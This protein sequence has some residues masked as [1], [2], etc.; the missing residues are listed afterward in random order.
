MKKIYKTIAILIAVFAFTSVVNAQTWSAPV[1]KSEVPVSGTAYYVFN[2]GSNGFLNRGA[3]WGTQA[4]VTP[5]PRQNA[6]TNINKWTTVNTTGSSWTF[7]YNN[8]GSVVANNY[9]FDTGAGTDLYTDNT[10]NNAFTVTETDATNHIFTIQSP[11]SASNY[12]GSALAA[13]TTNKGIANVV[14]PN[15]SSVDDYVKWKFVS[16]AN[17]DLYQAKVILDRYMTYAKEKGG[18]SLTT[19]ISTYN[20]DVTTDITTASTNLLTA[21]SRTDLTASITNPS[22]EST[23]TG[24]TNTG[25]FVTQTNTPGQGWTK[26]GTTYAEKYIAGSSNLA[27]GAITQTLTGLSNGIYEVVASGHAVQQG[28]SNPLHTGAFVRCGTSL[29]E[30]SAGGDYVAANAI[31]TDGTLTVGYS[32]QGTVACNWTGFDNFRLYYYGPVSVSSVATLSALSLNVGQLSPAFDALNT[33]YYAYIPTGTTSVNVTATKTDANSNITTG[34]SPVT[35][36]NGVGTANVVVTAQDGTTTKTYT[37]HFKAIELKHSYTFEDG[38]ANDVVGTLNGTLN[39]TAISVA[40]GKCTVTG[41]TGSTSGYMTVDAAALALNTYHAITIEAFL[42]TQNAA[43]TAYTMLCYFGNNTGGSKSFWFQPA[44]SG[45]AS[46]AALNNTSP[47]AEY[48]TELDDGYKHYVVATLNRDSLK[49]Y[50]DGTLV[51]GTVVSGT[52]YIAQIDNVVANLFKG[53]DGWAD[54]NYNVSLDEFNIYDG[55]MSPSLIASKAATFLNTSDSKLASLSSSVGTIAPVFNSNKLTYELIVPAG[56]TSLTLT[57]VASSHAAT[58]TGAG[59]ISG[60][61]LPQSVNVVVKAQD[62][63]TTSTNNLY[64]TT[65]CFTQLYPTRTNIVSDPNI[66]DISNFGGWEWTA[67]ARN[68]NTDPAHAYCGRFS[69]SIGAVASGTASLDYIVNSTYQVGHTYRAHAYI[70]ATTGIFNFGAYNVDAT[71]YETL[72]TT[73]GSWEAVNFV[74]TVGANYNATNSGLYFNNYG[75]TGLGGYI[76][77]LELYD[78]TDLVTGLATPKNNSVNTFV[79]DNKIVVNMESVS[80]KNADISVYSTNG[81]LL[82]NQKVQLTSGVTERQLNVNLPSGVYIVKAQSNEFSVSMKITK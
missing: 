51:A 2:V 4:A 35:I 45:T 9:L 20:S 7:Q 56:T 6:S 1:Y 67:G 25:S 55:N 43:N 54:P 34:Y 68:L 52:D 49:Y 70:Y 53:P 3:Y 36:S 80:A 30:V 61:T 73:T 65:D 40:N 60:I 13:E 46:R 47:K 66:R 71:P 42:E 32:L 81:M 21:L 62:G 75:Q 79:R 77:N 38:T 12:I 17:Y 63:V 24:W 41:A 69:G 82:F 33:T 48:G 78:I 5:T 74:F 50:L 44:I 23:L 76:D 29:A 22:F 11:L 64:I 58:I 16:Q 18:I 28:G 10:T 31:V 26:A 39:G 59:L 57:A 37:I 8:N 19:Y 27:A 14:R 72:T 15:R